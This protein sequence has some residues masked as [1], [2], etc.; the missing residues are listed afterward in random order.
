MLMLGLAIV[1]GAQ[2]GIFLHAFT[3]N[4][5]AGLLCLVVP[6]YVV[7]YARRH[8]VSRLF[9]RAW[10]LGMACFVVGAAVTSA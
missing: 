3:E 10:Y 1:M 7:V 6:C 5:G 9:L 4:P 2:I 8:P